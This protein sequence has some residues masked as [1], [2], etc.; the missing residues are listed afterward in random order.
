MFGTFASEWD[1]PDE[2]VQYGLVQNV[3]TFDPNRIQWDYYRSF[4]SDKTDSI[5]R[6]QIHFGKGMEHNRHIE[7]A[8]SSLVWTRL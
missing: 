4:K 5:T 7:Q 3:R 6:L 2:K 8:S 1:H